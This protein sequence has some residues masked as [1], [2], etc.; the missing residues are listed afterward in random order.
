[1]VTV[2]RTTTEEIA[3]LV[4]PPDKPRSPYDDRHLATISLTHT[5]HGR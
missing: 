2:H 1:M 5:C 3:Q 4:V